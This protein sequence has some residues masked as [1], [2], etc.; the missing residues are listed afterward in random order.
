MK[1]AGL[2][3]KCRANG[4]SSG[5]IRVFKLKEGEGSELG[6]IVSLN[7]GDVQFPLFVFVFDQ[8]VEGVIG[9]G[10]RI[11]FGEILIKEWIGFGFQEFSGFVVDQ[12]LG[13]FFRS[14]ERQD[15]DLAV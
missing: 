3:G 10:V 14:D 11:G 8:L 1:S 9:D 4:N 13:I 12:E 5:R 2:H 15:I 6:K 7:F